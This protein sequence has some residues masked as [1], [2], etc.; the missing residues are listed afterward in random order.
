MRMIT[1]VLEKIQ[2]RA[3]KSVTLS[4]ARTSAVGGPVLLISFKFLTTAPITELSENL[5]SWTE[6]SVKLAD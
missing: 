4:V 2:S 1:E 3:I 5:R 6:A